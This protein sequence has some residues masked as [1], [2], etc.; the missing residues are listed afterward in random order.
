MGLTRLRDTRSLTEIQL[1]NSSSTT[2]TTPSWH[3]TAIATPPCNTQSIKKHGDSS[4]CQAMLT[5]PN[6]HLTTSIL[7]E[8]ETST[9]LNSCTPSWEKTP[10]TTDISQTSKSCRSSSPNLLQEM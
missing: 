3:S 7:T 4:T 9:S 6:K 1:N 8:T 5:R 2:S 10:R